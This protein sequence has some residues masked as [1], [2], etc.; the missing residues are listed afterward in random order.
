MEASKSGG[1]Q[2]D[3]VQIVVDDPVTEELNIKYEAAPEKLVYIANGKVLF[4]SG[5]G[6][7]QYSIKNLERFLKSQQP[8]I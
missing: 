8:R 7:F 2:L 1:L 5:Q 6:P 3:N 4:A